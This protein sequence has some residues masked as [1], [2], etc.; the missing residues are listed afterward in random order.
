MIWTLIKNF[1]S[2]GN[3]SLSL[4]IICIILLLALFGKYE[5]TK[6]KLDKQIARNEILYNT[7]ASVKDT[8]LVY[9]VN[10]NDS[11]KLWTAKVKEVQMEKSSFE[12]LCSKQADEI[13]KLKIK[14]VQ[15]VTSI[16]T[17][18]SDSV[19]VPVYTDSLKSLH[20]N[21]KD[22]FIDIRTTIYRNNKADIQYHSKD[23]FTLINNESYKKKF[24]FFKW[25]KYSNYQ[26]LCKNP[27]TTISELKVIKI[28][29]K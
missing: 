11:V 9:Q 27:N 10:W 24:L 20:A 2:N 22:Q 3:K 12:I 28:V 4:L 5:I 1:I 23:S 17:Q 7:I 18:T 19:R 26:L 21:Y 6:N 29:N 25:G 8:A 16:I 15:S 13:N 14:K